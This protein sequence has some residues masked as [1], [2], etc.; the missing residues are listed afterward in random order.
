MTFEIYTNR[1]VKRLEQL[2][3][4]SRKFGK[5]LSFY[6]P[7]SIKDLR[8]NSDLFSI[9][10]GDNTVRY[11]KDI[12]DTFWSKVDYYDYESLEHLYNL[13]KIIE[14]YKDNFNIWYRSDMLDSINKVNFNKKL[15][16]TQDEMN[17]VKEAAVR[18]LGQYK[19]FRIE[20]KIDELEKDFK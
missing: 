1:L 16:T 5:Y 15:E 10:Y 13:A 2:G 18:I 12:N 8:L 7:N 11:V 3:Y 9:C 14:K 17:K 4:I 19:N 6:L 20:C